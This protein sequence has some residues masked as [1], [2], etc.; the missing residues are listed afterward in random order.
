[1][2]SAAA[3]SHSELA[4]P[5]PGRAP[6][7]RTTIRVGQRGQVTPFDRPASARRSGQ[8]AG[9]PARQAS[10]GWL[11]VV[12]GA[13]GADLVAVADHLSAPGRG[14]T[15]LSGRLAAAQSADE[16]ENRSRW[17]AQA[18][19]VRG[20][21]E[22]VVIVRDWLSAL[23]TAAAL[24]VRDS[25][26]RLDARAT[27]AQRCLTAGL[28]QIADVYV[29]LDLDPGESMAR[30][31]AVMPAGDPWRDMV[32]VEQLRAFWLSPAA[33]LRPYPI[34]SDALGALRLERLDG[35]LPAGTIARAV[36]RPGDPG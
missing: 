10:R 30:M 35:R 8:P 12:D 36:L 31:T 25:G 16:D 1:M 34:L 23:A 4:V 33:A 32:V 13:P 17:L 9:N 24:A 11:M 28:L 15:A 21:R 20:L 19:V 29:V 26:R 7:D 22:P 2:T 5:L 6:G 27:W 18:A 14:L 3:A